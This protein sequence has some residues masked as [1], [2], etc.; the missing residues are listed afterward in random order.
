MREEV[1]RTLNL[2]RAERVDQALGTAMR[3]A[4]ARETQ[5]VYRE[6]RLA[7]FQPGLSPEQRRLLFDRVVEKLEL[8]LPR[9]E[10][11]PV[12]RATTW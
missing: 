9:G 4:N 2:A 7:L 12:M 3:V 10:L 1:G 5:D 8:P 6:Y 11:Q